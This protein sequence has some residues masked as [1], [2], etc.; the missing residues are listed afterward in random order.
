MAKTG[1]KPGMTPARIDVLRALEPYDRPAG[2]TAT[3]DLLCDDVARLRG[4]MTIS[5][6]HVNDTL[7]WLWR[8]GYLFH[9]DNQHADWRLT[10]KG[11]AALREASK[12]DR[13]IHI[14]LIG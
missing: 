10:R 3:A 8:R 12:K 9:R 14:S 11:R 5:R 13:E 6:Q 4:R 1:P 7:R 2:K